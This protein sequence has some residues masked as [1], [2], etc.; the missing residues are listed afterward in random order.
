MLVSM[1]SMSCAC[2]GC[3][4]ASRRL[5]S[6][7]VVCILWLCDSQQ[8]VGEYVCRDGGFSELHVCY[9]YVLAKVHIVCYFCVCVC[10]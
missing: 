7:Y 1:Y 8:K 6:M 4:T 2:C 9:R 5:V 10:V 3:V